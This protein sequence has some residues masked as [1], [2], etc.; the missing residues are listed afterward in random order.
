MN[1]TLILRI[2]ASTCLLAC[3]AAGCGKGEDPSPPPAGEPPAARESIGTDDVVVEPIR[4]R[5]PAGFVQSGF[6]TSLHLELRAFALTSVEDIAKRVE[7]TLAVTDAAGEEIPT[8]VTG[9]FDKDGMASLDVAFAVPQEANAWYYAVLAGTPGS[10]ELDGDE[11][12]WTL[13]LYTGHMV[14]VE[15][16]MQA[17]DPA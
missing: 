9:A 13:S 11:A 14:Y 3:C 6:G 5:K 8:H 17:A 7:R 4:I 10:I 2:A 15:R 1:T 16:V 12:S